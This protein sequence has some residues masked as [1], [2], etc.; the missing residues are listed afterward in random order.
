MSKSSSSKLQKLETLR[1]TVPY[2]S[3]SA[4][5][6]ILDIVAAEG[7][8]ELHVPKH[9]R[10]AAESSLQQCAAYG[11]LLKD[12]E[13]RTLAGNMV[14]MTIVNVFSLL[15][16]IYKAG[17]AFA[18]LLRSC[19]AM[20]RGPLRA[21]FYTDE[22]TPG[23]IWA[24]NPSRKSWC[25]Y[26]SFA[27]FPP[28]ILS[29]EVAWVTICIQRT[30]FVNT[31]EGN[32]SQVFK[33]VLQE[34]FENP[35]AQ[36]Q[37]GLFLHD[38]TRLAFIPGILVQDGAAHKYIWSIKGDSG[39]KF[40]L[41]C[42][43]CTSIQIPGEHDDEE[44]NAIC[45]IADHASL[46]LATDFEIWESMA[47]LKAKKAVCS[48]KDFDHW[49]QAT[50]M[51]FSA[52]S[53]LAHEAFQTTINPIGMYM[54]DWMHAC[55]SNGCLS[56]VSWLLLKALNA[57]GLDIFNSLP[58]YLKQWCLPQGFSSIKLADMFSSK[59]VD[60]CKKA[61]KLKSTASEMLAFHVVFSYYLRSCV[62]TTGTFQAEC[63][64][65]LCLSYM[66]D[67][68]QAATQGHAVDA[69]MLTAAA[70]DAL[71][72][73]LAA[74]WGNAMIKKF[75]WLLHFGDQYKHHKKLIACFTMERKHKVVRQF[76]NAIHNS[77]SFEASIYREVLGQELHNLSQQD[78]L[79]LGL[80]LVNP[81]KA[82]RQ[83]KSMLKTVFEI[84]DADLD[85]CLAARTVRLP[86]AGFCSKGDLCLVKSASSAQPW[87]AFQICCSFEIQAC[88]W[89][90]G[91]MW[92][93]QSV[94]MGTHSALWK[95]EDKPI[96]VRTADILA[97]VLYC[98]TKLGV[99]T[100]IPYCLRPK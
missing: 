99:R 32:M 14:T 61:N 75:H 21:I 49:Q 50:G 37:H 33:K 82:S 60:S 41:L 8:P 2:C 42:K 58:G 80:G 76:A 86:S 3:K 70:D 12:V 30:S 40:C 28:E 89:T 27:D 45:K 20:A 15:A 68:L 97:T 98:R 24:I 62:L 54:R 79:Q 65:F 56:V 29:Q 46:D 26:M 18:N 38:Y 93:L 71:K 22:V 6:E 78:N 35:K 36:P 87:D 51:T 88:H 57:A 25:V 94:D 16:G 91:S 84:S 77:R 74:N 92:P 11:P 7:V 100:L 95:E 72:K 23:N 48:K 9:M 52:E 69:E 85:A 43:N 83:L 96:L 34:M 47:R 5:S 55:L 19:I 44:S 10:Q 17:G 31:L 59:R 13:V 67:L 63:D 73:M 39:S 1:R 4:L 64:A 81:S 90:L 53:V 66:V